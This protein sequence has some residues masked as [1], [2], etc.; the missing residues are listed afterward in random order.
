MCMVCSGKLKRFIH[1][2]PLGIDGGANVYAM[3]NMNP[4]AFIDPYG[5]E[6]FFGGGNFFGG[7]G[8]IGGPGGPESGGG[9]IGRGVSF[10]QNALA[11]VGNAIWTGVSYGG[12][13][14]MSIG[15]AVNPIAI[16]GFYDRAIDAED[17]NPA[18][19]EHSAFSYGQYVDNKG[20]A[21]TVR[22]VSEFAFQ[23]PAY[24]V[25]D[26]FSRVFFGKAGPYQPYLWSPE[27]GGILDSFHDIG[28]TG[29]GA[30]AGPGATNPY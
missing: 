12:E 5:L 19:H 30:S 22:T 21:Q 10:V 17:T 16:K 27:N 25:Q 4:L 13:F 3:A 26:M 14:G 11:S 28:I 23:F 8:D 29:S 6:P 1:P 24:T 20:V 18:A 2:D 15:R 7:V 9:V